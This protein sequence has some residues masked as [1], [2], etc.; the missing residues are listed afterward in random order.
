MAKKR[1]WFWLVYLVFAL[2]LANKTFVYVIIPEAFL[3]Y[4][5]WIF[6]GAAVLLL[7]GAYNSFKKKVTPDA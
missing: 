4:E 5:R 2:Y 7:L 6:V 3:V 1:R